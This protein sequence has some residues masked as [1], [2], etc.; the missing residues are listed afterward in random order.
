MGWRPAQVQRTQSASLHALHRQLLEQTAG[1]AERCA[2]C[3]AACPRWAA[4]EFSVWICHRCARLHRWLLPGSHLQPVGSSKW[5]SDAVEAM[6]AASA[7]GS[8]VNAE[9]EMI[10]E[11]AGATNPAAARR[12]HG[13]GPT[14]R[15]DIERWILAKSVN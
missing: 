2:D 12:K 3:G 4:L 10:A 9:W 1:R 6:C 14:E 5:T 13:K 11:A 15:Y 7:D 8:A